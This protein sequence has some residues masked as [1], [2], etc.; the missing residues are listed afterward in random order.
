[1][2]SLFALTDA[3][4]KP[5]EQ[6]RDDGRW[7]RWLGDSGHEPPCSSSPAFNTQHTLKQTQRDG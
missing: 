2:E 3:V 4:G 6:C 5:S 1:M 7:K